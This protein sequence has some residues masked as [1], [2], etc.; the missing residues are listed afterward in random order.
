MTTA[1]PRALPDRLGPYV[2]RN[3]IGEGGMGVV[4]LASGPE[5]SIVAI[6]VLRPSVVGG[7]DGRQRLAREVATMRRVR[8]PRVAEVL[9]ADLDGPWPYLVMEYVHGLSLSEAVRRHGTMSGDALCRL[10]AGL[11]EALAEVHAA[12]LV[13]RDV[14][15]GNVLLAEDGPVLIDFGL[16][17]AAEDAALTATGFVLGTPGFMAPE[18]VLGKEPTTAT[19]VHGWGATLVY[20]AGGVSPYGTG[21]DA[22]VLDRIRRGELAVPVLDPRLDA[23][24]RAALHPETKHRP[25]VDALRLALPTAPVGWADQPKQVATPNAAWSAGLAADDTPQAAVP[26]D[27]SGAAVP[28]W[29]PGPSSSWAR[30]PAPVWGSPPSS[31][32][33]PAATPAGTPAGT[34]AATPAAMRAATPAAMPV[35]RSQRAHEVLLPRAPRTPPDHHNGAGAPH[36]W[37]PSATGLDGAGRLGSPTPYAASPATPQAAPHATPTPAPAHTA[38]TSGSA[39]PPSSAP[40]VDDATRAAPPAPYGDL[41]RL[42]RA[43][44]W[45]TATLLCLGLLLMATLAAAPLLGLLALTVLLLLARTTWRTRVS[46]VERRYQRGHRRGDAPLAALR[47]P[48][49]VVTSAVPVLG[50]GLVAVAAGVAVGAITWGFVPQPEPIGWLAGSAACVLVAALGPGS[51]RSRAGARLVLA[52]WAR[53]TWPLRIAVPLLLVA[54]LVVATAAWELPQ[55]WAPLPERPW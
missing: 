48:W 38:R 19:D 34:P 36:G 4:H 53:R 31:A 46:L 33:T 51:S 37:T 9:D 6:K 25:T 32:A 18:T 30:D 17:R 21:P 15:P 47:S 3:R 12:G 49:Y 26:A 5:G 50:Q 8:G 7:L 44:A 10:A 42:Q 24:V 27:R 2:L 16:A 13:H 54:A 41:L 55:W 20:A 35:A 23:L 39:P 43:S 40:P 29:T 45:E 28:G 11:A 22:V 14:K 52:P 1:T